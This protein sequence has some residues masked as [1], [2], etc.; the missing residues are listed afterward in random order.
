M[1][2]GLS[3][4]LCGVRVNKLPTFSLPL[5]LNLL[6][7]QYQASVMSIS[8]L[9]LRKLAEL[10]D[11]R[12]NTNT[13]P[14]PAPG[15]YQYVPSSYTS[16]SPPASF[17]PSGLPASSPLTPPPLPW[18]PHSSTHTSA[19]RAVRPPQDMQLSKPYPVQHAYSQPTQYLQQPS[20]PLARSPSPLSSHRPSPTPYTSFGSDQQSRAFSYQKS[21]NP[22]PPKVRK[23]LSLDGGGV[24]GLSIIIILKHIMRNLNKKRGYK[25]DPWQEFDMIG[26]T[27][28]GG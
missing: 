21:A 18:R 9:F 5:V 28:T 23:V 17:S 26:G 2:L 22:E 16:A 7:F 8:K 25:L 14:P 10:V 27:S 1:G 3:G 6:Y 12:T 4:H 20:V 11:E 15:A 19:A 13:N 24:R